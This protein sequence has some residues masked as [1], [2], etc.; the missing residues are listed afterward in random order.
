MRYGKTSCWQSVTV[1]PS[2]SYFPSAGA[3]GGGVLFLP[4]SI[5]VSRGA[6]LAHI[7]ALSGIIAHSVN[8]FHSSSPI[9]SPDLVNP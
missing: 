9:M 5:C 1:L 6:C 8:M 4:N 2:K 3:G 7:D